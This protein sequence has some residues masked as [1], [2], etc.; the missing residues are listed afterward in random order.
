MYNA[1]QQYPENNVFVWNHASYIWP[2]LPNRDESNKIFINYK[3]NDNTK[4][5]EFLTEPFIKQF[6]L[7]N[8]PFLYMPNM[9]LVSCVKREHINKILEFTGKFEDGDS[10]DIYTGMVNLFIE[11]KITYIDYPLVIGGYSEISVGFFSRQSIQSMEFLGRRFRS[12]YA[13]YRYR[14][15]YSQEFRNLYP[16]LGFGSVLLLYR[17]YVKVLRYNIK[18]DCRDKDDI[19]RLLYKLHEELPEKYCDEAIYLKQLENIAKSFGDDVYKQYIFKRIKWNIEL[20]IKRVIKW[21][22]K[23]KTLRS[24]LR[25][26]YHGTLK[27]LGIMNNV[28]INCNK[29]HIQGVKGVAEYLSNKI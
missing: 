2:G 22:I 24:N 13:Y 27:L 3:L 6:S 15:Y 23:N 14:N 7:S 17:E 26:I 18:K 20:Y 19:I 10:Q 16:I 25:K 1:I 29:Y 9:Y 5:R 28:E 4:M 8:I 12:L 11:D 21:M